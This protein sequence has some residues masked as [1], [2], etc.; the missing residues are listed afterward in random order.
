MVFI[1]GNFPLSLALLASQGREKAN[2][3]VTAL[4]ELDPA[5]PAD[6]SITVGDTF[7]MAIVILNADEMDP[8]MSIT[9]YE[10]TSGSPVPIESHANEISWTSAATTTAGT[11]SFYAEVINFVPGSVSKVANS[12]TATVTISE[13]E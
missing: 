1:P 5:L 2:P 8:S 4:P 9:W 3:P 11:R 7:D 12:R 13:A 6:V 10:T